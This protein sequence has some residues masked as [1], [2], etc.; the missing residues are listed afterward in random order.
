[1]VTS[2]LRS[3]C[4]VPAKRPYIFLKENYVNAVAPTVSGHIVKSRPVQSFRILSRKTIYVSTRYQSQTNYV[5]LSSVNISCTG[6]SFN[7]LKITS[8]FWMPVK[9]QLSRSAVGICFNRYE[10]S[11]VKGVIQFR[12]V[13]CIDKFIYK[14]KK[15]LLGA[16]RPRYEFS[17]SVLACALEI[18]NVSINRAFKNDAS[19]PKQ[20]RNHFST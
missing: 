8:A 1:M 5:R 18:P 20:K 12:P 6:S 4:F 10:L 7:S 11:Y 19:N 2:I 15:F 13:V 17:A 9:E 14:P 16:E 3:F